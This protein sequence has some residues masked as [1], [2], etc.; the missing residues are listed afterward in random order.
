MS[1]VQE[2]MKRII[3]EKMLVQKGVAKR[4]G[5]SEQMF[6]AIMNGRKVIRADMIPCLAAALD[7]PITEL[8]RNEKKGA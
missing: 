5:M 6:S 7:V 8:F 1:L 2:N 3:D 4:A